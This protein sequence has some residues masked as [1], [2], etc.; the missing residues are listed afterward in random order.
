MVKE[1][2]AQEAAASNGRIAKSQEHQAGDKQAAAELLKLGAPSRSDMRYGQRKATR[3][4][5]DDPC[6]A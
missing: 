5:A 2:F 3:A 1:S 4:K 6:K